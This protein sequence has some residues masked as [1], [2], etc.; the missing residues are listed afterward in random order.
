MTVLSESLVTQVFSNDEKPY[1]R[2]FPLVT[3]PAK[4][5]CMGVWSGKLQ[6]KSRIQ[7]NPRERSVQIGL[8][9][10]GAIRLLNFH[11]HY[12]TTL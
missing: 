5:S 3:E 4:P 7:R 8:F 11:T 9:V 6:K 12:Y 1:E 10:Q 2:Y